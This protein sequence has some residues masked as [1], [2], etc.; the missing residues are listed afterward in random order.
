MTALDDQGNAIAGS[1]TGGSSAVPGSSSVASAT[2]AAAT[3]TA[4]STTT[5]AAAV[6]TSAAASS[7]GIG[8]FGKCSVPQIEFG[9]GFDNRKETSFEPVDES[10]SCELSRTSVLWLIL[11][12]SFVQPRFCAEHRHYLPVYVR[13]AREQLWCRR[14]CQ[15]HLCDRKGSRRH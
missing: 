9:V 10:T 11:S 4:A 2:S 12:R 13:P 1:A 3:A 15:S 7:S 5:N 8:N 14:H 6:Q